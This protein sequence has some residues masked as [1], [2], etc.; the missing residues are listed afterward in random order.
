MIGFFLVDA[1]ALDVAIIAIHYFLYYY[2][3]KESVKQYIKSIAV[4]A[5][6]PSIN[7]KLMAEIPILLPKLEEQRCI[8][9]ILSSFDDKIELNRR[10]MII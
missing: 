8:A 5:T 10:I 4:G 2:F 9:D 3:C 7:T 1:C 6:M